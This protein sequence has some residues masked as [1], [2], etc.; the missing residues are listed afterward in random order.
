MESF[1][2]LLEIVEAAKIDV[3]KAENGNKAAGTRVR[4]DMQEMKKLA[5]VIRKDI[6]GLREAAGS[7]TCDAPAPESCTCEEGAAPESQP[8]DASPAPEA[9][10]PAESQDAE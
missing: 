1:D 6:L 8:C 10:A 5:Q 2:R 9:S 4:K 3:P 7:E